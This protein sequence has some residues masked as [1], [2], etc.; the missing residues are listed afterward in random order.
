[1]S[2]NLKV[3][4]KKSIK[5][6][7]IALFLFSLLIIAPILLSGCVSQNPIKV[8]DVIFTNMT[9]VETLQ[10]PIGYKSTITFSLQNIGN[11][12][13]KNITMRV[14]IHNKEKNEQYNNEES[15]ISVLDPTAVI[16]HKIMIFY[17]LENET[18]NLNITV[19]WD[20]GEHN[21][22]R[23]FTPEIIEYANVQLDYL[24]HYE[25]VKFPDVHI[26]HVNRG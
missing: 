15:V 9:H 12:S 26:S 22:T 24:T 18:M 17:E 19:R 3:K 13:A 4:E 8:A 20:T 7:G 10:P 5:K 14:I 21:Y 6:T 16:P 11:A 25:R 23:S 2:I 1:M